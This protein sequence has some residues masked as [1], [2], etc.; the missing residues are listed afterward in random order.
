M[1]VLTRKMGESI[2]IGDEIKVTIVE[3]DGNSVKIG[4]D[5]PRSVTVHREEVYQRILEEN[6]QAVKN[7]DAAINQFANLF[8]NKNNP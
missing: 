8:K 2:R 5:A 4:I 3:V 1:L 7:T 6:R